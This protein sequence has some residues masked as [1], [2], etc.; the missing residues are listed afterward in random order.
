MQQPFRRSGIPKRRP[1]SFGRPRPRRAWR[2]R[3]TDGTH[4]TS[5]MGGMGGMGGIRPRRSV[6][7]ASVTALTL[8]VTTSAGTGHLVA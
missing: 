3:R 1:T 5:G 7:I 8:A 4:A 2:A 6:V